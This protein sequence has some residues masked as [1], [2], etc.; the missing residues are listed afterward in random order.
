MLSPFG[1]LSI[2]TSGVWHV[3]YKGLDM[4]TFK[5][6]LMVLPQFKIHEMLL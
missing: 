3:L 1:E 5:N 2:G 6:V 4:Q